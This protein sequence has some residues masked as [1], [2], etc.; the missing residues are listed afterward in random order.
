[1]PKAVE[2]ILSEVLGIDEAGV[3]D[4]HNPDTISLWDSMNHLRLVTAI[5]EEYKINLSMQEIQSMLSVRDIKKMLD[6]H[7][8]TG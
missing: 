1:M 3:R 6:N 8:V 2:K 4:E 5:E 7:S